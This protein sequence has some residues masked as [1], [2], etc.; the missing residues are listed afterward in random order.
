M[1][2]IDA[3]V[4]E[5]EVTIEEGAAEVTEVVTISD[6]IADL[7]VVLKQQRKRRVIKIENIKKV[8][9]DQEVDTVVVDE[10]EVE[11]VIV[12]VGEATGDDN[13]VNQET[14]TH[15]KMKT[16]IVE[17]ENLKMIEGMIVV[18]KED[19][20][21]SVSAQDVHL[22]KVLVMRETVMRGTAEMIDIVAMTE[23][24]MM[25]EEMTVTEEEILAGEG[26]EVVVTVAMTTGIA[27][28]IV[29]MI[30]IDVTTVMMVRDVLAQ[31]DSDVP[32]VTRGRAR[33]KEKEV[34]LKES[35]MLAT[36]DKSRSDQ[37][38]HRLLSYYCYSLLLTEDL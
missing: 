38:L 37:S 16:V 26:V 24:V 2:Q 19:L 30:E 32:G 4:T 34:N 36:E 27:V 8:M 13:A 29:E 15:H 9:K 18:M 20:E 22:H 1:L 21:D 10:V 6:I 7:V 25:T 17:I 31:G 35:T 23:S 11:E 12:V 5:E 14:T 28:M 3:L 33:E